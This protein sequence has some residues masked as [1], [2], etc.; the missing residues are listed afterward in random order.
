MAS[1]VF[2]PFYYLQQVLIGFTNGRLHLEIE[3]SRKYSTE[4]IINFAQDME[5][6]YPN[7]TTLKEVNKKQNY[8]KS[9][10]TI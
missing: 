3:R 1:P 10:M 4:K 6:H 9:K 5:E 7:Q 8:E 2:L